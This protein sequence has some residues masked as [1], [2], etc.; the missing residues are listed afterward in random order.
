LNWITAGWLIILSLLIVPYQG[1]WESSAM[2]GR[3][4]I[5]ALWLIGWAAAA[6][7]QQYSMPMTAPDFPRDP[8]YAGMPNPQPAYPPP[9]YPA[10][11]SP[12][13]MIGQPVQGM[14]Y[15]P[16]AM[17]VAPSAAPPVVPPP[18]PPAAEVPQVAAPAAVEVKPPPKIWEG[19]VEL[20]VN[21]SEGNSQTLNVRGGAKIK[22]KTEF[23]VFSTDIDYRKD[24][25]D[26]VD[27]ANKAFLESRWERLFGE[28]PWTLF[29]HLTLDYDEFQAWD[30]RLAGDTGVGYRLIKNELTQLTARL[31]GGA[32][33]EFGGDD[34]DVKPEGVFGLEFE[35]KINCRH[36]VNMSAEYRPDVSDWTDYRLVS[37][38]SWEVLLDEALHL[39]LKFGVADR[40][41]STPQ[42]RKPNDLDYSLV[43]L[44]NF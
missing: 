34:E 12:V 5:S 23:N 30:V 36:K 22:R 24:T 3:V 26:S 17:P 11:A 35:R 1:I 41:D 29:M 32:S 7:A 38:A 44:F 20:G 18:V 13:P 21:G 16:P 10:P 40:Y 43:L 31:G 4:L 2:T 9:A 33:R 6:S 27:T 25:A 28:S 37:K 39:S 8:A 15:V 42:G 14:P 19:S